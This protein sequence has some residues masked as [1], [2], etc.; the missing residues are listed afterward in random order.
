MVDL[1]G[2]IAHAGS[3]IGMS[4]GRPIGTTA[5]AGHTVVMSTG[6]PEGTTLDRGYDVGTCTNF[7]LDFS[8]CNLPNDWDV[9]SNFLN[10]NN[11]L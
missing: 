11:D 10:V 8:G 5:A 7:T 2:T 4:G 6:R 9:S 1:G 3:S